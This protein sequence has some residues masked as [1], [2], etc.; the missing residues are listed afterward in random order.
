MSTPAMN[1][2]MRQIGLWQRNSLVAGVVGIALAI[3]AAVSVPVAFLRSYLFGYVFWTGMALGCLGILLMHH[4]VGG[5]W[6]IVIRRLCEAG[7]RTLPLMLLLSLPILLDMRMIYPWAGPEGARDANVQMKAGYLNIPF[8]VVRTIFYFAVWCYYA[9]SL[10]RKSAEQD[11]TGDDR[12]IS[13]MRAVS[14]PGLVVFTFTA[15]FAF[16]DWIMSLEP[17]WFSTVYGAMFLV[18]QVLQAFALV[19]ALLVILAKWP[20]LAGR[21]TPQHFHDLGNMMFAFTVLWAYLSFSQY[22]IIWAGNLPEEI[23]WYIKRLKTGW[24]GIAF[25]LVIFHFCVPFVLLLQRNIKR[26]SNLLLPMCMFM[27]AVRIVDVFWV[28]APSFYGNQLHVNWTDFVAPLAVG[29]VWL[30]A[31]FWQLRSRP[32][33]PVRDPALEGAPRETVAF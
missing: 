11:Q 9:F 30:A 15:T 32:L 23:P 24:G 33:V 8:F 5:K 27:L 13:R 6:G 3:V 14:A 21:I 4:T 12:L 17:N 1:G 28:V 26:R 29:G 31:F 20:P 22:I 16:V 2:D 7:A 18:G 10:S 25:F 19:I